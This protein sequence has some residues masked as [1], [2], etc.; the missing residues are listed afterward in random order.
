MSKEYIL[1]V[2]EK[3]VMD[4]F[5]KADHYLTSMELAERLSD[6]FAHKTQLHRCLNSLLKRE[7]ICI[8][9]VMI[10][11]KKN[12]R[13]FGATMSKEEFAKNMLIQDIENPGT[14]EKVAVALLNNTVRR[15]KKFTQED[16]KLI[17]E[18]EQIIEEY[19]QKNG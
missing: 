4:E 1:N 12:A 18:L 5:W 14:L 8:K 7:L 10:S 11:G 6:H 13:Q 9:G 2:Q 19:R 15:K 16:E 17:R 3:L